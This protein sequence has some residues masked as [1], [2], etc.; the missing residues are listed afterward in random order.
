MRLEIVGRGLTRGCVRDRRSRDRAIAE[1]LEKSRTFFARRTAAA[2]DIRRRARVIE[3]AQ[4]AREI[5]QRARFAGTLAERMRGFAFKIDDV[6][7]AGRD[8]HLAKM[9]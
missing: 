3:R 1:A 7:V 8:E 6:H 2:I 4:Q 5:L 9:E